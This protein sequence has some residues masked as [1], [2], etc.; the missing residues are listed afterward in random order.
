M[1]SQICQTA[2]TRPAQD[3][4]QVDHLLLH[5]SNF[6]IGRQLA[7]IAIQEHRIH[8]HSG[9]PAK[10]GAQR[11]YMRR[12]FP[13]HYERM[14]GAAS[15]L[16]VDIKKDQVDCSYLNYAPRLPACSTVYYP[17]A[18]TVDGRALLSRN[19]DFTT[20]TFMATP[21]EPGEMPAAAHA[22][23]IETYPDEGYPSLYIAAFDLL[24]GCT[25][26][27]NAAGLMVALNAD[28]E[29]VQKFP[30]MPTF[31]SAVGISEIQIL[32][33]LLETCATVEEAKELM[34]ESKH[35]YMCAPCH[36]LI[37]DRSGKSFVW[38]FSPTR[39]AELIIDGNQRPQVLTNHLLH[40]YTSLDDLP[41]DDFGASTYQRCRALTGF[42]ENNAPPF[43]REQITAFNAAV[44]ITDESY[45][46]PQPVP[47]RT[48]WQTLYDAEALT[49]DVDFYLG[50]DVLSTEPL[51]RKPRR[52][53]FLQFKLG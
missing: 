19:F 39:N 43:N 32:R 15:A 45:P 5:G 27:I 46:K 8:K 34:L 13:L 41:Q 35:F 22:Y 38:E 53:G 36:Y 20:G 7:I 28:G 33:L 12:N 30:I 49:M 40:Y 24:A 44:A 1:K 21:T 10:I 14:R 29:S 16:G 37:S 26:G 9:D 51:K 47:D 50:D 11:R 48:L 31:G 4:M 6:E 3:F 25:D 2:L 17:P 23:V 52:S 18:F 42:I